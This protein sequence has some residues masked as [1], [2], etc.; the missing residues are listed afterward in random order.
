MKLDRSW[1]HKREHQLLTKQLIGC[2]GAAFRAAVLPLLRAAIHES[3]LGWR[4][5]EIPEIG[6]DHIVWRSGESTPLVT[7]CLAFSWPELGEQ[8]IR[9]VREGIRRFAGSAIQ[10]EHYLLL[11]N[12]ESRSREAREAI[13]A[14]LQGLI[15][16]SRVAHAESWDRQR[17]LGKAFNGMLRHARESLQK[18]NLST[19]PLEALRRQAGFVPLEEVPCGLSLLRFNQHQLCEVV[20]LPQE[21]LDPATA[22]LDPEGELLTLVTG[23]FGLGKTTAMA[24]AVVRESRPILYVAG[25]RI[26]KETSGKKDFLQQ[27]IDLEQLFSGFPAEDHPTLEKLARAVIEYLLQDPESQTLVIIDGLDESAFLARR[28]GGFQQ[29][30]NILQEIRSPIVLTLRTELW[31]RGAE[32][33]AAAFGKPAGHGEL[34]NR[35]IRRIDLLAWG[36][37][38]IRMLI[39]RH[40]EAASDPAVQARLEDLAG[41]LER[42][43]LTRLYGDIPRRPLF[44]RLLLDTVMEEGLPAAGTGRARLLHDWTLRKLYRDIQAPVAAGGAGRL[45]ILSEDESEARAVE[46]AWEAML[47][48]A[49]AMI[50]PTDGGLELTA[51]CTLD[52]IRRSSPELG[53]IG[54]P[55]GIFL[56]S[57]L[58]SVG[59]VPHGLP[60]RVR[61]AHRAFQEFFLAWFTLVRP[62]RL[63]PGTLPEPVRDWIDQIQKEGLLQSLSTPIT[64]MSPSP[65][66]P[67]KSIP[68]PDLEI[69]VRIVDRFGKTQLTY[70]LTSSTGVVPFTHH[71]IA[72][73]VLQTSPEELHRGFLQ[74]IEQLGT[75]RDLGGTLV[76][77]DEVDRKLIGIGR[78]LWR[79]LFSPEMR[80]AYRTFRSKVHSLLIVSD[81]PWIPWEMVKP[82]EDEGEP[83]DD[84]FFAEQFELARWLAGTR[85]PSVDIGVQE[86]ACITGRD[87]LPLAPQ[88]KA[89]VTSLATSRQGVR[90]AT[91]P[92]PSVRALT[93]LLERGGLGLLHFAQHGT[94]D[95]AQPN[96]AGLPLV[97]G[98]VFRPSDLHGPIQTQVSKDRPLVVL[99]ACGSGRQGWSWAGLSG[100]ADRWVRGCGCG[101]FI[102]PLWQVRDSAAFA[103]SRGLYDAL[104]RGETL[105][106]AAQEARRA[107]RE[108][109]PGEPSWLA[110]TVYGHPNARVLLGEAPLSD[111]AEMPGTE[112][113]SPP[114]PPPPTPQQTV[115]AASASLRIK[116]RFSDLDRDRFVEEAFNLMATFFETSLGQL[117]Q[118]HAAVETR[119]RRIDRDHFDAAIYVHGKKESSCRIWLAKGHIGDI[120]YFANDSGMDNSYNEALRTEDDGYAMWLRP[121]GL[122]MFNPRRRDLLAPHEAAEYFWSML[123]ERLQ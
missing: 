42:G 123:I 121:L 93:T 86:L 99:N 50:E 115:P 108:A 85:S 58:L 92:M 7:A 31:D 46:I 56:N 45:P 70:T 14:E 43:E 8:E 97:D 34:R 62:G 61:F 106:K 32:S 114:P 81:E 103:F 51:D 11:H 4:P 49:A 39:L 100:W 119:F 2:S 12:G 63:P 66:M 16:T 21:L 87:L 74:H 71:E 73:P 54:E 19:A 91:P 37:D 47:E 65:P 53:G 38:R 52:A 120:A 55:L 117:E 44:L 40:R 36:D 13:A 112:L 90:D 29:L 41:R 76:L 88:E 23:E 84:P 79:Q 107:A 1:T 27:C 17:L 3:A 35:K 110:Y 22:I 15:T 10:T 18:T 89:L 109:T 57:L 111:S 64:G 78:D 118:Q 48:A 96:E 72:G 25:A 95:P 69:R 94:F 113:S 6:E 60:L 67:R 122:Q 83:L 105:G 101:A 9:K 98:S 75:G 77:R 102:G 5:V 80:Q 82:F 68:P 116:K 24:R 104:A 26:S 28:G 30:F 20:P 59:P 33:F